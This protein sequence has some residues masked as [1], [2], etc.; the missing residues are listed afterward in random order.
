MPFYLNIKRDADIIY[1]NIYTLN[2]PPIAYP[3]NI[4]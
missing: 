4:D 1:K 3:T 2:S